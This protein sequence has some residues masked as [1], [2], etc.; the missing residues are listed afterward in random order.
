MKMIFM[1][2]IFMSDAQGARG[3]DSH[4]VHILIVA[5]CPGMAGTVPEFLGL[6]LSHPVEVI[7]PEMPE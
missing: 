1:K 4:I 7:V 5:N 6:S 3:I 2:T